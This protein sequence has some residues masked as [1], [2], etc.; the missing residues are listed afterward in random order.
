ITDGLVNVGGDLYAMGVSDDGDPWQVGVRDPY[1]PQRLAATLPV[2]DRAIATS[3]D[4]LQ[5]FNHDGRRYHHLL[6]P[7][8]GEPRRTTAHS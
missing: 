6:D 1:D 4:Y 3:G 8:S 2:T 7:V 5:F